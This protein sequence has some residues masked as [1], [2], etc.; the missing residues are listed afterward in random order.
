MPT[1]QSTEEQASRD[2]PPADRRPLK[3]VRPLDTTSRPAALVA[4]RRAS[5]AALDGT[6][7]HLAGECLASIA[8]QSR[9][10]RVRLSRRVTLRELRRDRARIPAA[11][12]FIGYPH[13]ARTGS[14][15]LDSP[16]AG[17]AAPAS[18]LGGAPV[19]GVP[20]GA[21]RP[22]GVPFRSPWHVFSALLNAELFVL[23]P[24]VL[25][26]APLPE[27]FA[28]G[29]FT[30]FSRMQLANLARAAFEAALFG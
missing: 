8:T 5:R 28:S 4:Q 23:I 2:R 14:Y 11:G 1:L 12:P 9:S 25:N 22:S 26:T 18:P 16:P 13:S 7:S 3:K 29:R 10:K 15:S 19:G 24:L 27:V 20:P 21:P 30:P 17:G 6:G